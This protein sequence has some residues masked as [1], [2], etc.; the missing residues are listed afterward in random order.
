MPSDFFRWNTRRFEGRA[1]KQRD[2]K[3]INSSGE[4]TVS[5]VKS[6]TDARQSYTAKDLRNL[7]GTERKLSANDRRQIADTVS[8]LEPEPRRVIGGRR[9]VSGQRPSRYSRFGPNS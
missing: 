7:L 8:R 1:L 3:T 9:T 6:G 2:G 4:P 5:L